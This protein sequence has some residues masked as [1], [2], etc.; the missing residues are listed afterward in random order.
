MTGG[1]NMQTE[2]T[3]RVTATLPPEMIMRA[4]YWAKK[5]DM[6]INQ[7]LVYA[8]EQFIKWDGADHA[9]PTK[10]A[11]RLNLCVDTVEEL[12]GCIHGLQTAI[13]SGFDALSEATRGDSVFLKH[14]DGSLDSIDMTAKA[15]RKKRRRKE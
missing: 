9:K 14:E 12:A 11:E 6:S 7:Y 4:G 10:E 1:V 3:I 8:L 5:H 15:K 2:G 13:D